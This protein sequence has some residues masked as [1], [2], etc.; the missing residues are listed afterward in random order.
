VS[1]VSILETLTS[2]RIASKIANLKYN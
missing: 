2:A 1:I